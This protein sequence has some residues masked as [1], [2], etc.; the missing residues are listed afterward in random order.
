[1]DE[2]SSGG[3]D[4][5]MKR[6]FMKIMNSFSLALFWL[7][8]VSTLGLFFGLG[9]ARNGIKWYNVVFYLFAL[10]SLAGLLYYFYKAW[11]GGGGNIEQGTRNIE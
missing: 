6:Y 11:R 10:G 7:L 2:Y 3:M 1:M 5:E 8:S 9:I 4:P